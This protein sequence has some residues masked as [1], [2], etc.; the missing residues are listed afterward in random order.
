ME[1]GTETPDPSWYSVTMNVVFLILIFVAIAIGYF[2]IV[3]LADKVAY[4]KINTNNTS[5][6][7]VP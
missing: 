2:S 6:E 4:K 7:F 3:K 5:K 1:K